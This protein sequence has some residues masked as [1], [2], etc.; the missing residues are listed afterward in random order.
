M[1]Y[2]NVIIAVYKLGLLHEVR[3]FSIFDIVEEKSYYF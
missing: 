3:C 1:L 2:N